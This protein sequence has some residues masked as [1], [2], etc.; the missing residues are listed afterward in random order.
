MPMAWAASSYFAIRS[1]DR[2]AIPKPF[3]QIHYVF[4]D[5]IYVPRKLDEE[6]FEKYRL[7]LEKELK[8]L[9]LEAWLK[10]GRQVH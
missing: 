10:T 8:D 9:Y 2:T 6:Q 4:G 3:S 5:A 1:W 7:L